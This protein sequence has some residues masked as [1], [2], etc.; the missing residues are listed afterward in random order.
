M[1]HLTTEQFWDFINNQLS[2]EDK[3]KASDHLKT[4]DEC[5]QQLRL[6]KLI[7]HDLKEM[8]TL[9]VSPG[10]ALKVTA[11]VRINESEKIF[12]KTPFILFK[13]VLFFSLLS[14]LCVLVI[15]SNNQRIEI[16]QWH[17]PGLN[18]ALIFLGGLAT[19]F[20]LDKAFATLSNKKM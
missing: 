14:L 13:W 4:C 12:N 3:S 17:L 6:V 1:K 20:L 11:K 19:V 8:K 10:F 7:E 2:L 16:P 15:Y 9:P 18:Y 5:V